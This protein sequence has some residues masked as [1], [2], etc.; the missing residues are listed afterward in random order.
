MTAKMPKEAELEVKDAVVVRFAGDSGDGMQTVG[1][2]FSDNSALCGDNVTT[3]PDFPSEIRAPAGSLP[4]VSGFQVNFGSSR[5]MTPGDKA[6]VLVAMNPAALKVNLPEL[7]PGGIL[8]V[9]EGGFTP[10]NLKKAQYEEPPLA[11]SS[12]KENY[13]LISLDISA[14]TIEAL[15]KSSLSQA[16][17]RRCKNFFALGK[18]N[19]KST[20]PI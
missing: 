6:D 8:I 16:A 3:F 9:N 20:Q 17:N 2:L 7:R 10:A 19:S 18:N 5:I 1:E 15:K 14:I 12:L 13:K 11:D 4:G